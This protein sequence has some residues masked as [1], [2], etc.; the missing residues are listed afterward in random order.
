MKIT[1]IQFHK[2]MTA[3]HQ[4]PNAAYMIRNVLKNDDKYSLYPSKNFT[5]RFSIPNSSVIDFVIGENY[6]YLPKVV[7]AHSP[8]GTDIYEYEGGG[9]VVA[10]L[11]GVIMKTAWVGQDGIH[12]VGDD[13]HVYSIGQSPINI[14]DIG[15]LDSTEYQDA[16]FYD[17][18]HYFYIGR[19]GIYSQI[20]TEP[21]VKVFNNVGKNV[22]YV[23]DYN[24][25]LVLFT[26]EK[27][28]LS[29][30]DTIYVYFWDKSDTELFKKRVEIRNARLLGASNIKGNLTIVY[31]VGN[32]ENEKENNGEIIVAQYN[33]GEFVKVN[34]IYAGGENVRNQYH[35]QNSIGYG[36]NMMII[37]IKDNRRTTLQGD[38]HE[39]FDDFILK[40]RGGGEIETIR[41]DDRVIN[42]NVAF[43]HVILS[44]TSEDIYSNKDNGFDYNIYDDFNDTLYIT[45]MIGSP[46]ERDQM[47]GVYIAFEK[48]FMDS[49]LLKVSFRTSRRD[50]FKEIYNMSK[51]DL[52][53]DV[54]LE[55]DQAF[56]T[57]VYNDNT[58][59]YIEQV[60]FFDFYENEGD[61][62]ENTVEVDEYIQAQLKFELRNGASII[63][64]WVG[65][66]P[67]KRGT[68]E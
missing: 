5:R 39:L 2:T 49:D 6:R 19:D 60:Y 34:S 7:I 47:R 65:Y 66:Q 48:Q 41:F 13:G 26:Q 20:D 61:F 38:T 21:P 59:G 40:I 50:D 33:G 22:R 23:D 45:N 18:L 67:I 11:P 31:F 32:S 3:D 24:S 16:M 53:D 14:V 36:N 54:N 25:D 28:I 68:Y 37:P 52:K 15:I 17:G 8:S 35:R 29:K 63:G 27:D 10:T 12:C 64:A 30:D 9:A 51:V 46:F 56:K 44:T 55:L 62:T 42:V 43:N 58:Q 1:P 4:N 57:S